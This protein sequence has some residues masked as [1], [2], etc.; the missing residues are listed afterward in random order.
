MTDLLLDTHA[1][2]W[3]VS[4]APILSAAAR[5]AIRN[6][7]GDRDQA[8]PRQAAVARSPGAFHPGANGPNGSMYRDIVTMYPYGGAM[9]GGIVTVSRDVVMM[10]RDIIAM[11]W[12]IVA[13]YR[14]IVTT[15]RYIVTMYPLSS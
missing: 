9:Y 13:T 3:W 11:C 10:Y 7:E 12:S 14:Y 5:H 6:P 1:F 15:C 8:E 4:D 2:L